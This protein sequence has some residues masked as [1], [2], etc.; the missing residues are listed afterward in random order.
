MPEACYLL[1]SSIL[2]WTYFFFLL[3]KCAMSHAMCTFY[4]M[5]YFSTLLF[6]GEF[7]AKLKSLIQAEFFARGFCVTKNLFL[8]VESGTAPRVLS[9]LISMGVMENLHFLKIK[10]QSLQVK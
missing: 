7:E 9:K 8:I 5:C 10:G 2:H 3:S 1:N 4:I 6:P